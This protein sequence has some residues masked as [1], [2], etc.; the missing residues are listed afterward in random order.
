MRRRRQDWPLRLNAWLDSAR[1]R[2]FSWGSHDC[3]LAAADAV[4]AMTGWDPAA[5]FR[6][7][8]TTRTGGVRALAEGGGLEAM[9]TA[10]LGD[11]LPTPRLAGR[12]DLVLVDGG[13]EGPALCVV[14]GAEAAGP[15]LDQVVYAPMKDWRVGWRV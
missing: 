13:P 14:L 12:G 1:N 9:V 3:V 11:P 6:G 2:P 4:V 7:R 15:G 5:E 10:A 8:Y